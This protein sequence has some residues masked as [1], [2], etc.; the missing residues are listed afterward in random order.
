MQLAGLLDER[1]ARRARRAQLAQKIGQT[2]SASSWRAAG[3]RT[4]FWRPTSTSCRFAARSSA[5]TRSPAPCSARPRTVST[6]ARRRLPR[7]WCAR[8][9]Q[10]PA[11]VAQRACGVLQAM[12]RPSARRPP[13]QRRPPSIATAWTCSPLARCSAALLTGQRR[14]RAAPGARARGRSPT[15][16]PRR[17]PTSAAAFHLHPARPAA[18]LCRAN[19]AAP[20]ARTARAPCGRRRRRGAGQRQRRG[21]GL[22]RLV[23]RAERRGRGGRRDS[24]CAS[25]AP[26]SSRFSTRR[27]LPSSA[28]PRPRCWKTHPPRSRPPAASTSRRTTT[29]SSRA[30]C[31][32]APRWA[33]RSTCR[34]CARW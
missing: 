13:L 8:P 3:A 29:A 5:S 32:C 31:R 28:S 17:E 16:K 4:R 23:R 14:Y 10:A 34:P 2:V 7:R 21:A 25:R 22:G 24:R 12:Q 9:T 26:R 6:S 30:G 27:P 15:G 18:A 20:A 1:L 19:P 11:Q 33:R